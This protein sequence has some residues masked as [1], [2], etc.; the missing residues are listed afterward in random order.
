VGHAV[1]TDPG[2]TA[3]SGFAVEFRKVELRELA[4]E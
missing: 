2:C 4:P 3:L 1:R